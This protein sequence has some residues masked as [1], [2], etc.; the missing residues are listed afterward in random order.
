M[1]ANDSN[2]VK[3]LKEGSEEAFASIYDQYWDK[4]YFIAYQKVK[5]QY[6]AEEIVQE[7][8]LTLWRKRTELNIESLSKYLAAMVRYAIYRHIMSEKSAKHRESIFHNRQEQYVSFDEQIEDRFILEKLLEL[9]NQLPEKCRLVFQ[10][11]KLQDQS[12]AD[13]A[14]QLNISQKTAEAHL[15]KALKSIRLNMRRFMSFFL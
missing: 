14:K 2:L 4:L 12:L 8:F 13:I 7:V 5:S 1:I 9:S 11:N 3:L 6:I 10:S 15:T